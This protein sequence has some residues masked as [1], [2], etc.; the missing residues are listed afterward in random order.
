MGLSQGLDWREVMSWY[1]VRGIAQQE[2][3]S[4]DACWLASLHGTSAI[5]RGSAQLEPWD[6]GD[7]WPSWHGDPRGLVRDQFGISALR[8]L[9]WVA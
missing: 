7:D 3:G 6:L 4:I 5:P 8:G 9:F 1:T 2:S